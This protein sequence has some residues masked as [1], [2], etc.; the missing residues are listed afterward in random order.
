MSDSMTET[1]KVYWYPY[2]HV[3]GRWPCECRF[4]VPHSYIYATRDK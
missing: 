1:V 2:C 4:R 3:C